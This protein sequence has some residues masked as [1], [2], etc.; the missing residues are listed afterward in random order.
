MHRFFCFL[1]ICHWNNEIF[2]AG[3]FCC[4]HLLEH[5]ADGAHIFIYVYGSCAGDK[6][7]ARQVSRVKLVQNLQ[8]KHHPRRWACDF[9]RFHFNIQGQDR[10]PAQC[11][12][13]DT[14]SRQLGI[15]GMRSCIHG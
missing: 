10:F 15:I 14:Q 9:T 3:A 8:H 11:G 1:I 6:F 5:P 12:D 4:N 2:G 7:A 13:V